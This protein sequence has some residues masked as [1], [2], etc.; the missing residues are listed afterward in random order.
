MANGVI[1]LVQGDPGDTGL[2][3]R[4]MLQGR[5]SNEVVVAR[6]G[7]EALDYLFCRGEWA[8]RDADDPPAI[9]LLDIRLPK[10]NGLEV[11]KRIRTDER[12]SRLPVVML[13][14]SNEE[15]DLAESYDLGANSF[16]RTP[17]SSDQF[18]AAIHRLGLYWLVVSE[19]PP[20]R[21]DGAV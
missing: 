17:V 2:A 10:I 14:S 5:I 4:R 21:G 18:A 12:T 11:L 20:S 15:E 8:G 16:V 9:V 1:P 19:P 13:T 3:L 6:D 7:Q